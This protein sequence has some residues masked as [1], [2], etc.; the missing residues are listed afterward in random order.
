MEE[1]AA[2]ST[3]LLDNRTLI[4]GTNLTINELEEIQKCLTE[5][6]L[7]DGPVKIDGT[8]V[9]HVDMA[10]IQLLVAFFNYAFSWV[11]GVVWQ[12]ASDELKDAVSLIG[13]GG[14]FGFED[15]GT[16]SIS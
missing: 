12:G 14:F 9:A 5:R 16:I 13:L 1:V 4:L 6:S 15:D 7:H 11:N 2:V 8:N 10:I 3:S